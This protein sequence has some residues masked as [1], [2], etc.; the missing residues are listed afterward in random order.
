MSDYCIL[1]GKSVKE[2][3][4][5]CIYCGK[6]IVH[7]T[8]KKE[9]KEVEAEDTHGKESDYILNS[10]QRYLFLHK[11]LPTLLIGSIIWLLS[12]IGFSLI[13]SETQFMG[14]FL[15]FYISM[16]VLE[17][18]LFLLLYFVAKANFVL[19]GFF[20]FFSFSFIAGILSIPIIIFTQFLPQV[21]MFVS[22]SFGANAIVS[23]MG[24]SLRNKY[25]AKGYIWAHVILFL[26]GC[27]VVEIIF[28][29][30][31]DIHNYLLTIPIT[32][33][34]ICVVALTIM[35]YGAK[36]MKK[37]GKVPWLI[38]VFRIL[39]MLLLALVLAAVLVVIVLIIIA[40]AIAC[41]DSDIDFGSITGG[42]ISGKR[43]KKKG[44]SLP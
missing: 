15:I 6:P 43:K 34:Y 44:Q 11:V 33:A 31:F 5:Y 17:I 41:G 20:T 4:D 10:D 27:V 7:E 16:A 35:F 36:V 24:I 19:L 23:L 8:P 22:L 37:T 26:I 9:K 14:I 42:G 39:A 18:I 38:I 12:E 1:C 13:F 30:V 25:F 29:L 21:H 32:L 3:Y 28:I 2:E 40:I